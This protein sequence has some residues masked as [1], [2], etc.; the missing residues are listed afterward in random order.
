[1]LISPELA[2]GLNAQVGHEY[3]ASLQYVSIASY[4][5][6]QTLKLLAKLF[7]EQA[8]EE[9]TH[10]E[11]FI[12]FILDTQAPLEIPGI[13]APKATFSSAEDAVGAALKWEHEVTGQITGLMDIAVSKNDYISQGFL[14]RF[15][16]EQLEEI[17]KMDQLLN[18]VQRSGERNLLMVEAYLVHITK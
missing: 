15:V 8:N 18:V 4:F 7:F 17:V 14:Q 13:P 12:R 10:A 11:K 2:K 9:K 3:G 5:D 6:R 16:D 1:V